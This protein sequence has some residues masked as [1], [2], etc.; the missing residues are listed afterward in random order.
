ML[1]RW[2]HELNRSIAKAT[3]LAPSSQIEVEVRLGMI[4][5]SGWS[6]LT[7]ALFTNFRTYLSQRKVDPISNSLTTDYTSNNIR[8]SVNEK[9]D[10]TWVEKK[11][12]WFQD[13]PDLAVRISVSTEQPLK[14]GPDNFSPSII[15]TKSRE[16]F[17]LQ[18]NLV[19]L[20]MT[21][22][23]MTDEKH[24]ETTRYE[25][26]LE[27]LDTT[28]V[29]EY[30]KTVEFFIKILHQ[31]EVIYTV[32]DLSRVTSNIL[33]NF[34]L[35]GRESW[36]RFR[37]QILVQARNLLRE[38]MVYGGLVGNPS[39][40]Y[41]VTHKADGLRKML[42][43]DSTGIWL[44]MPPYD[45]CRLKESS[46]ESFWGLVLDGE[47]V[48]KS[49]QLKP[50]N[51]KYWY[52]AF[53]CI[54]RSDGTVI[55][56]KT[57]NERMEV[58]N[59]VAIAFKDS[60]LTVHTKAFYVL[61]SVSESFAIMTRMVAEQPELAYTNDGFMF[62]PE[63]TV[64]NSEAYMRPA[65]DR[66]LTVV[67][68]LCK[69]KPSDQLTIDFSIQRKVLPSGRA[70]LMLYSSNRGAPPVLFQGT[71][72][73][74]FDQETM[75][76]QHHPLTDSLPSGKIV[77]YG[78]NSEKG[79]FEPK[80]LRPDKISGNDLEVA[81][82]IWMDIAN[83]IPITALTGDDLSHLESYQE[84][85]FHRLISPNDVW[86]DFGSSIDDKTTLDLLGPHWN[87]FKQVYVVSEVKAPSNLP[88]NVKWIKGKSISFIHKKLK[89]VKANLITLAFA[90]SQRGTNEINIQELIQPFL[91][92]EKTTVIIM[93]YEAHAMDQFFNSHL[94]R[95]P[96]T[97][98]SVK[99]NKK[100]VESLN[101]L[102]MFKI[103][104][105]EHLALSLTDNSLGPLRMLDSWTFADESYMSDE[106]RTT[107]KWQVVAVYDVPSSLPI[108]KS[109]LVKSAKNTYPLKRVWYVIN[110]TK[111]E[112]I[113]LPRPVSK[114][115]I[116]FIDKHSN[117]FKWSSSDIYT[118]VNTW[119][120][121]IPPREF[122]LREGLFN[123]TVETKERELVKKVSPKK[124]SPKK[125]SPKKSSPKK[126]SLKKSSPPR[127]TSRRAGLR[128]G[129]SNFEFSTETNQERDLLMI[130][131]D[132]VEE[133]DT[134]WFKGKVVRI[135]CLG[136]GNSCF[137]HSVLK[138]YLKSYQ[139]DSD[140]KFRE[141]FVKNVRVAAAEALEMTNPDDPDERTF[142]E[143]APLLS[144]IAKDQ[145]PDTF[146]DEDVTDFSLEGIKDL[147]LSNDFLGDEV[148]GL[149]C[150]LFGISIFVLRGTNKDLYKH[151]H[152][153]NP[154]SKWTVV[155]SGNGIHYELVGV[156]K[157]TGIQTA[158]LKSDAFLKAISKAKGYP[159]NL[160]TLQEE[161][162]ERY[163]KVFS[164]DDLPENEAVE[165]SEEKGY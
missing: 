129:G 117:I 44:I 134:S 31:T 121:H 141:N 153:Q 108:F 61:P 107:A 106:E 113:S 148:Y 104:G 110:E 140:R 103:D 65:K 149:I 73:N 50:I 114:G 133:L 34:G 160:K 14:K 13:D 120:T 123:K 58:A 64:Y 60:L 128:S 54:S 88:E 98:K 4:T 125:S 144:E 97:L 68:D 8:K 132:V 112:Y 47:L 55:Q 93:D 20:D 45:F 142:Y 124:S 37:Q 67:P 127:I 111:K 9:G 26:E 91:L 159:T 115:M 72:E 157:P 2:I 139:E 156:R 138:G 161:V 136:S 85:T 33:R 23:N 92:S 165:D 10:I 5:P 158:F 77:E 152:Y 96:Y 71:S 99:L 48:P 63:N 38:D 56:T 75:V 101:T 25:I 116:D 28:K 84:R 39:T 32:T 6:P 1:D 27:L 137:F 57:H 90:F 59:A 83:P 36:K 150:Q 80:K 162:E 22:V 94:A 42:V 52:L 105:E 12:V 145:D 18:N 155:I 24:Q 51:T 62:T 89:D 53:D 81:I 79:Y 76:L 87:Q 19:R 130:R 41:S 74:P 69:W 7:H 86:I 46:P 21:S 131:D 102:S 154:H 82:Q 35:K 29:K 43:F 17:L 118:Y 122:K 119:S 66:V 40:V 15:R 16:S 126:S 30:L 78:W 143:T 147:L 100:N 3:A 163:E 95:A 146:E 70:G 11:S 151:F 164:S 109:D 49:A 135:G